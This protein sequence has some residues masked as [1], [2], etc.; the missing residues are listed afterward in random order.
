MV[1][2]FIDKLRNGKFLTLETTPSH[3]ASFTPIIEYIKKLELYK[4][5]DGFSTTDSPLAKL[6]YSAFFASLK[7]QN[8]FKKPVLTTLTMRD[9]NRIAL[10]GELLGAN[11]FD[12]RTILALTGDPVKLSDQ[13][14]AKGVFEGNS[15]LLLDIITNFNN[16]RDLAN[17]EFKIA[18]KPIYPFSV[19]N[20]YANNPQSLYKKMVSKLNHNTTAI[21]TQPVYSVSVAKDLLE[22]FKMAKEESGKD[23]EL[24]FGFFPITKF[25]TA[26]FLAN[27]L[28]GVFVPENWLNKLEI[29]NKISVDE[30]FKV[31][32]EMSLNTLNEVYSFHSKGHIM[33]ANN[34]ELAKQ[35]IDELKR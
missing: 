3:S 25:R 1:E 5:V 23:G 29:A 19:I 30:E 4:K 11:E 27:N 13:P 31:G 33:T 12:I 20:S 2:K 32:F 16:G 15:N 28:P 10:Q 34:F 24:I 22:M 21:I 18:P 17:K 9:R 14:K 6:R 7:L 26:K 35:L 8:E